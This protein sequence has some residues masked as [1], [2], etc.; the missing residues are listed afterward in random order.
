[1]QT[2]DYWPE[3][4]QYRQFAAL[5]HPAGKYLKKTIEEKYMCITM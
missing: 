4:K 3:V 2:A 1:V 5:R